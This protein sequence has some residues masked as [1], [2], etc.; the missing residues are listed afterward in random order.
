MWSRQWMQ[1]GI[2]TSAYWIMLWLG[3]AVLCTAAIGAGL[4]IGLLF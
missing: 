4:A 1:A 3:V 2:M